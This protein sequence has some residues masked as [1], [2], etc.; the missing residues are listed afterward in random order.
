MK[1]DDIRSCRDLED[2][3]APYV[4]DEIAPDA[5]RAAD[6]HMNACPPCR[7]RMESERVARDA[8]HEHRAELRGT[9]PPGLRD[10]CLGARTV[11]ATRS[12]VRRWVPLWLAATILL[13]VGAVFLFGINDGVQALAAGLALDHTKC[14][15][16]S[17]SGTA[18]SLDADSAGHTWQETQGWQLTVPATTA[19]DV[20]M[21]GPSALRL[22]A[23]ARRRP[24]TR[25]RQHGTRD[26]NLVGERPHLRRARDRTSAKLRSHRRLR[27]DARPMKE[28][29]SRS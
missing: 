19:S 27:E 9:A 20:S 23:A 24:C 13:A 18:V 6:A 29:M 21:G 22:R 25:A 11:S 12:R 10:R 14:F 1:K 15:K 28:E 2:R 5:R 3:L 8:V 4:D 17:T 16:V 26:G 7:F